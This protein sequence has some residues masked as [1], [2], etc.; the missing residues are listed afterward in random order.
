MVTITA[1]TL[2]FQQGLNVFRMHLKMTLAVLFIA[3]TLGGTA[4]AMGQLPAFTRWTLVVAGVFFVYLL[5]PFSRDYADRPGAR[6]SARLRW[7]GA[8]AL[9]LLCLTLGVVFT[10]LGMALTLVAG[11]AIHAF[12]QAMQGSAATRSLMVVV[13]ALFTAAV[14]GLFFIFRLRQRLIY[15][16]TEAVAGIAIAAHR[17]SIEPT[18]GL[19]TDTGFYFAVLTAGIYLVVRGLDNMHQAVKAGDSLMQRLKKLAFGRVAK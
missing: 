14:G 2:D 16:A 18:P 12:E 9:V 10:A 3:A 4:A 7:W 19:P 5:V 11:F 6:A 15:G 1:T 13:T 17:M 8:Y